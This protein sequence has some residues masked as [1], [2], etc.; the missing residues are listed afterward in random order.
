MI[1][2]KSETTSFEEERHLPC[3]QCQAHPRKEGSA[4]LGYQQAATLT[5]ADEAVLT[6]ALPR[7]LALTVR[8]GH[9]IAHRDDYS[10]FGSAS[11]HFPL[12]GGQHFLETA[13]QML[14]DSFT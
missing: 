8:V 14:S 5:V 13:L 4:T 1:S 3:S 6:S 11:S 2:W 9:S 7:P 12:D 10:S